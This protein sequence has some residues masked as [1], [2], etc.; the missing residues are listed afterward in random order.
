VSDVASKR[1]Y[2]MVCEE[3]NIRIK[4]T[5]D[6]EEYNKF[7]KEHKDHEGARWGY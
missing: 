2:Y 1:K 7:K 4:T 5:T 3:C 6:P